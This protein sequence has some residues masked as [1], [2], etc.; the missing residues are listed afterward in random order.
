MSVDELT[1]VLINECELDSNVVVVI[2]NIPYEVT[3]AIS[4]KQTTIIQVKPQG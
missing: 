1:E 4:D 3:G 2:N